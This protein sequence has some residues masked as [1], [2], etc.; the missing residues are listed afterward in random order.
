MPPSSPRLVSR[1][2]PQPRTPADQ[3]EPLQSLPP[4]PAPRA[5]ADTTAELTPSDQAQQ[6]H[7]QL[8]AR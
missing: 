8:R 5:R 4:R 6:G 1:P 7:R 3:E 2:R